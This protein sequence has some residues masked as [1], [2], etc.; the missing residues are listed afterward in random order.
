MRLISRYA[1]AVFLAAACFCALASAANAHAQLISS[2]P[3]DG[4]VLAASPGRIVLNF[5]ETVRPL[6]ARLIG[7]DGYT[8]VLE[9]VG[10]RSASVEFPLPSGLSKG[11]HILSWRVASSDGH[12]IGGGLY[13]SVGAPS[14]AGGAVLEEVDPALRTALWAARF[15][16]ILG[17]VFGVGGVVFEG[18]VSAQ[19]GRSKSCFVGFALAAGLVGAIAV[20]PLQGLDSLGEPLWSVLRFDVWQTGLNAT[21]YGLATMIAGLA[22]LLAYA[23][24][25]GSSEGWLVK[26]LAASALLLAGLAFAF[27]GH[28]AT[29]PPRWLTASAVFLHALAVLF[30]LGALAP[31]VTAL[32]NGSGDPALRR[33]STFIPAV[34]TVLFVSG[35]VIA[36]IQLGAIAALWRTDYGLVMLAKLGLVAALLLL[37]AFNRFRLTEPTLSGDEPAARTLS[38]IVVAE[39]VLGTLVIGVLGL[40][41]F[42]PPPRALAG[43]VTLAT[44]S[45]IATNEGVSAEL[46]IQPPLTGSVRVE[47]SKLTVDGKPFDAREIIIELGKPS[48]GIGPFSKTAQRKADGVYRAEGFILPLDG[49][50]IVT[51]KVLVSDFRSVTLTD[52]F[53][54]SKRP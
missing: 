7:P 41:R 32:R 4:S 27:A 2:D 54:V 37:A 11:T 47:L 12:P 5:T 22:L 20:V 1:A 25:Q 29:A 17:L 31:L 19:P 24:R 49:F 48:Y 28:A 13:F 9:Q 44:Q 21:S 3:A 52:V 33:F 10:D 35:G 38:R 53:D 15:L 8:T 23:A 34:L 36:Y 16:L 42:T 43:E 46:S 50:W 51:V 6:V 18:L 14:A 39:I 45:V 30:W 40:W 26:A